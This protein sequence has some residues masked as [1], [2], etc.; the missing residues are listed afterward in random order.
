MET[1][2]YKYKAIGISILFLVIDLVSARFGIN[3]GQILWISL[4]IFLLLTALYLTAQAASRAAR[5]GRRQ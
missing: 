1:G 4:S 3:L 2:R 5:S